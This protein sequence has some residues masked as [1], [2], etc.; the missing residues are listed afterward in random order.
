[1]ND[2]TNDNAPEF[3]T[4][5][6]GPAVQSESR[7]FPL[8]DILSVTTELLLSRRHMDGLYEILGYMTGESLFTHQ[9]PRAN[10]T[11]KPVLLQQHPQLEGIAPP[12]GLDVPDLMAWLANAEREYG[13][14]LPVQPLTAWAHQDP[15][16]ELCD[17]V[18]PEK[19]FVVPVETE[20]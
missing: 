1:M 7:A 13:E 17:M 16:E 15:I 2:A 14:T 8:S 19:V 5:G 9:L 12:Q 4:G 3:K 11:C 20:R 6:L 10:D 18:G